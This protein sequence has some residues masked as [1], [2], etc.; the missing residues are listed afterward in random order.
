[1]HLSDRAADQV[2][3]PGLDKMAF[4]QEWWQEPVVSGIL[5]T[6]LEIKVEKSQAWIETNNISAG[7]NNDFEKSI[8]KNKNKKYN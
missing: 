4:E 1:M 7:L 3:I 2:Q 5:K 8:V 6:I